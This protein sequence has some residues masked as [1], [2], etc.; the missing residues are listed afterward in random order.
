[1]GRNVCMCFVSTV[2]TY[3]ALNALHALILCLDSVNIHSI[4]NTQCI[5][6]FD[7]LYQ[8]SRHETEVTAP[9]YVHTDKV[10]MSGFF[11][12]GFK[13]YLS[14]LQRVKSK[15]ATIQTINSN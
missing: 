1:M 5:S 10:T 15:R 4:Q 2:S 7:P 13:V 11:I 3:I 14:L 9:F 6:C 8:V 12:I